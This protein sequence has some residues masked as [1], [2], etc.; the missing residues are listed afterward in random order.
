MD[1][2]KHQTQLSDRQ[3]PI[4]RTTYCLMPFV[5]GVLAY[6]RKGPDCATVALAHMTE[7]AVE[8]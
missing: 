5:R 8:P 6:T 1:N 4:T 2:Q 3:Q 7:L